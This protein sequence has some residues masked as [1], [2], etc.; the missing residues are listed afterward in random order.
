ME[1]KFQHMMDEVQNNRINNKWSSQGTNGLS[2]ERQLPWWYEKCLL[3][4]HIAPANSSS[5]YQHI[6]LTAQLRD[7]E[8]WYQTD[9]L[10]SWIQAHALTVYYTAR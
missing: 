3:W 4:C 1:L 10:S 5:F 6:K 7:R 2:K 9:H 8:L